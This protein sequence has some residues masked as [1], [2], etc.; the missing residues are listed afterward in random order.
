MGRSVHYPQLYNFSASFSGG[1][2]KRLHEYARWFDARGGAW[3]IVHPRADYL[4]ALFP[5]NRYFVVRQP[6]HH[7]I[8]KDAEYIADIRSQIGAPE[9]YYAY[10]IPIYERVGAINWFHL[11]NVLTVYARNVPLSAFDRLKW[12]YLG[13]RIRRNYRHADVISAESRFSLERMAVDDPSKLTLSVNGSDDELRYAGCPSGPADATAV[14]VGTYGYKALGDAHRVF[15]MLRRRHPELRLVIIGE[16][17]R[18]PADVRDAEGVQTTGVLPRE[19]VMEHLRRARFYLSATLIENSYNAASEGVFLARESYLSDIGPHR[20][21]LDGSAFDVVSIPGL[22]RP[23]IHV[24]KQ[25]VAP[26][27][28]KTWDQVVTEMLSAVEMRRGARERRRDR[29]S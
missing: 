10:G 1:G 8:Y 2:L 7:R 25:D 28:L 16:E 15:T 22:S 13:W 23:M 19:Q 17:A 18:I 11:S 21:L 4:R 9:L 24:L 5:A 29:V 3:F 26:I 6:L 27:R 20:E 14:L 12:L